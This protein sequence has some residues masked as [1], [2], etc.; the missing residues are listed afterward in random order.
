MLQYESAGRVGVAAARAILREID[1]LDRTWWRGGL[2]IEAAQNDRP[3]ILSG[4]TP[5]FH[6]HGIADAEDLLMAFA[7]S[8]FILARL[9]VWAKRY[10]V[11][12]RVRMNDEDWGA[13]DPGGMTPP[14]LEQMTKWARRVGVAQNDPGSWLIPEDRRSELLARHAG[15]KDV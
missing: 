2:G 12:W 4:R 3:S 8:V 1:G 14:L 9:A 11:K 7:D 5:L 13:V 15:R 10:K 6:R